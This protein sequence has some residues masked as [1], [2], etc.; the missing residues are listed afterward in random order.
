MSSRFKHCLS[1]LAVCT[2]LV[3]TLRVAV[4]LLQLCVTGLNSVSQA[5]CARLLNILCVAVL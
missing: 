1:F 4:V 5:V 3:N 2:G